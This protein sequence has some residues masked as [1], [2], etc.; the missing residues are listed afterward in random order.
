MSAFLAII[1]DTVRLSYRVGGGALVGVLFFL[2]IIVVMP[3]AIGPDVPLLAQIGPAILWIGSLLATLLGLDR[4][5][6][7]DRDDGTL[8]YLLL[9]GTPLELIVFAKAIGHWIATVLPLVVAAPVLSLLLNLD[10]SVLWT[11]TLTLLVG[12]P[13]ITLIGTIGAAL[14][15]AV[16][17]GGLL[18][19]VLILPFTVPVLI[20]G[21]AADNAVALG[22]NFQQPFLFLCAFT[23]FGLVVGP[24]AGAGA[25]R[26]A[27][28]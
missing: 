18:I 19:A 21:V 25:I 26:A 16:R 22:G 5:F 17:R 2:T 13:A 23:L 24:I 4:L 8:D 9:S 20:F 11:V 3:F 28:E 7:D 6:Q 12:T 15:V 14:M 10:P 1:R 27:E